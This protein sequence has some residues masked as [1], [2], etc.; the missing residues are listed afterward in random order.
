MLNGVPLRFIAISLEKAPGGCVSKTLKLQYELALSIGRSL[1]TDE[2]VREFLVELVNRTGSQSA[3]LVLGDKDQ[4]EIIN[5]ERADRTN[6]FPK[7]ENLWLVQYIK[8]K[9]F[10]L[11]SASFRDRKVYNFDIGDGRKIVLCRRQDEIEEEVL[12]CLNPIFKKLNFS[13]SACLEFERTIYLRQKAYLNEIELLEAKEIAETSNRSKSE[14]LANMSHELRTPMNGI[15]GMVQILTDQIKD[16][17]NLE[18]IDIIKKSAE[19]LLSILNDILDFSK[20]EAGKLTLERVPFNIQ[21]EMSEFL[22]ISRFNSERKDL[23]FEVEFDK[24]FPKFIFGDSLRTKQILMN[25]VGNSIKF[26][27]EGGVKVHF[28]SVPCKKPDWMTVSVSVTDT[29]PGIPKHKISDIFE[30]FT[31]ADTSTSRKFGGTG[32]GLTI[33]N[34]L[35]QAMGGGIEVQ[36][37]EGVGTTFTFFVDLEVMGEAEE[38][39]NV[40]KVIQSDKLPILKILVAEDNLI[41]QLIIKNFLNSLN[42]NVT[43][44]NDGAEA[45]E[46]YQKDSFD[47]VLMDVQM[48]NIN[49][50]EATQEIRKIQISLGRPIPIIA[51]TAHAMKGDREKCLDNGMDDHMTKPIFKEDLVRTIG[52]WVNQIPSSFFDAI[53]AAQ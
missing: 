9:E 14:F 15:I 11:E 22:S 44:V 17:E 28:K 5:G 1:R 43:L 37:E 39:I 2:M 4:R 18:K 25:L 40:K 16:S 46:A 41:N 51:L 8:T 20:I 13:I 48:P 24:N 36:S 12:L 34:R 32:L 31:Q 7:K 21:T 29:G 35:A 52:T 47:M 49:G 50:Y 53:R 6:S 19:T 42:Q 33:S 30:A 10:E 27:Q 45:I 3:H 38:L 26:T 23:K